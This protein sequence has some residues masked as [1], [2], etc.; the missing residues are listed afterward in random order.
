MK[1]KTQLYLYS[2][3]HLNMTDNKFYDLQYYL[4]QTIRFNLIKK[5]I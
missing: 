1:N 2:Y 5:I 3:G 4:F